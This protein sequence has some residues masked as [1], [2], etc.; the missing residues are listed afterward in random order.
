MHLRLILLDS[1]GNI[2]LDA[3]GNIRVGADSDPCCCCP[4][5][6]FDPTTRPTSVTLTI[7]GV[8]ECV[9]SSYLRWHGTPNGTRVLALNHDTPYVIDYVLNDPDLYIEQWNG[10]AWV[11]FGGNAIFTFGISVDA[12]NAI[13]FSVDVR[14]KTSELPLAT[15]YAIFF[16]AANNC[17]ALGWPISNIRYCGWSGGG[18]GYNYYAYGAGGTAVTDV[19]FPEVP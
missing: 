17:P 11:K 7:E 2:K 16:E 18:G 5:N 6:S 19:D 13:S 3:S 14:S 12:G 8:T 15:V 4:P 9:V 1:S 10:F